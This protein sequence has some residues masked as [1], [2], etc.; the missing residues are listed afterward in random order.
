MF[1]GTGRGTVTTCRLDS[2]PTALLITCAE[3]RQLFKRSKTKATLRQTEL[4]IKRTQKRIY[5]LPTVLTS[6]L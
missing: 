5:E 4:G 2:L 3:M 1:A 6:L